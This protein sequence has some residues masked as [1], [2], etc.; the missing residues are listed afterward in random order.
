MNRLGSGHV[1]YHCCVI[2]WVFEPV[3]DAAGVSEAARFRPTAEQTP[4]AV[5]ALVE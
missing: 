4:D 5:T 3:E 2:D 1:H